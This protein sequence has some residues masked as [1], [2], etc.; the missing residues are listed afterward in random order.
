MWTGLWENEET[1]I[2]VSDSES[3]RESRLQIEELAA[4]IDARLAFRNDFRKIREAVLAPM[5]IL[6]AGKSRISV[7]A[8]GNAS[9]RRLCRAS[10]PGIFAGHLES[11]KV[12]D[13]RG[14]ALAE[15]CKSRGAE[16][17]GFEC[18]RITEMCGDAAGGNRRHVKFA[19]A[20][21]ALRK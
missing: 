2:C 4:G 17:D 1:G 16:S 19:L 20:C 7:V 5:P 9:R 13:G 8:T 6:R 14:E 10:L 15:L 21:G 11:G 3:E 18:S 12:R